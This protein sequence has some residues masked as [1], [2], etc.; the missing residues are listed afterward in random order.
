MNFARKVGFAALMLALSLC[1]GGRH[2][3]AQTQ[4][5]GAIAGTITDPS[6]AAIPGAKITIT[7]TG[8][9]VT[10]TVKSGAA[11]DFSVGL[12]QPGQYTVQ[13]AAPGFRTTQQSVAVAVGQAA[14]V[15]IALAIAQGVQTVQVEGTAV[16]ILQ[17]ENSNLSTTLTQQQVQNLP[18]PG[19]D[20]TDY[21]NM[22]AGV[23]E[24]TNGMYG[25]SSAFGLPATSNNFTIN[26]AE[27]DDPFLNLNNSGPSNLLLG[28]N[29]ISEA[30]IVANAYSAQYGAL[31]G[32]Q[33]NIITRSGTNQFHGNATWYWTNSDLNANDWFNDSAGAPEPFANANQW[34]AAVGGPIK[35]D[36]A[37]FFVNYE[38]LRFVTSPVST[39]FL[40]GMDYEQNSASDAGTTGT[41]TNKDGSTYSVVN[42]LSI[43][44]EDGA[45]DNNT[46]TLY[47]NG[48]GSECA[49]YQ[50]MFALYNGTPHR[51]LGVAQGPLTAG[52]VV[53]QTTAAN[54]DCT[55][56]Y[57]FPNG[58]DYEDA[59]PGGTKN[60][61]TEVLTTARLDL[62]L[63]PNDTAFIHFNRDNGLQP[64][65]VDPIDPAAFNTDSQQPDYQGQMEETHTFSPTLVN[66]FVLSGMWYSALFV[67]ANPSLSLSTMPY[68]LAF[69]DGSF[70]G[71]GAD[72][73]AFP[74]G[75]NVTQAQINDDVSWIRGKHTIS[76]GFLGKR[77]DV[78]DA[79]LG[80][81]TEMEGESYGP[82]ASGP[83]GPGDSF[84][85]GG[86]F[87]GVMRFPQRLE[88][89]I[90]TLNL[91]F[92][93]QDEWKPTSNLEL[94]GGIRLEHNE[95]PACGTSC[96][97]RLAGNY[98]QVSDSL[99]TPYNQIIAS[100]L[101]STFNGY[102]ALA[103]LPRVG[104][105]YSLPNHRTTLFRGGFGMFTDVFPATIADDLLDNAPLNATFVYG[106]GLVDPSQPGSTLNGVKAV[107]AAF[108][109]GF[110]SGGSYTSIDT[111]DPQFANAP[112]SV[113]N[114][115]KNLHYPTYEEWSV[116]LQQ[117]IGHRDGISIG[118]VGNHGYHE[119]VQNNGVNLSEAGLPAPGT[120]TGASLG[121]CGQYFCGL[122]A[123]TPLP[124]FDGVT[125]VQS[126]AVS[127][128]NG[129]LISVQH[130][131][132][133]AIAAVNY[134]WSHA[135][136][137]ISN[138]GILPFAGDSL[139]IIDP[140]NLSQNYG[141][142]DYDI[143]HNLNANYVV[144]VPYFGGPKFLTDRWQLG[145]T[146]FFR[147]GFPFSVTDSNVTGNVLYEGGNYAGSMLADIANPSVLHTHCG[148]S[149]VSGVVGGTPCLSA[150]DFSDP[151]G[152]GDA[153]AQRR[154][155]FNGPGW[156]DTDFNVMK[157]FRIPGTEAG[158]IQIGAV[159][160][161]VLNH[162]NFLNPS[163]NVSNGSTFGTIYAPA[164]SVPTSVFGAF[165]GGDASPRILQLKANIQF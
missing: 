6:G 61:L 101:K 87:Y 93:A 29:D 114:V 120:V 1:I 140:F 118:Y 27:D 35:H 137:E 113:F 158:Q 151:T 84:S 147:T 132:K 45:C 11:G 62:K 40:P 148:K 156:F 105:T 52:A 47:L 145:G 124:E 60:D 97:A 88:E 129:L 37:W 58:L 122:P 10:K 138:G 160:Y 133:V 99:T 89:P 153:N 108:Q 135:M 142:A 126:A 117:Q 157:G 107:N 96:F 92:Y 136:D 30:S 65:G 112:P 68:G 161:N 26:G 12:L 41:A 46:S 51:S 57:A 7:D 75:R 128:Y 32:V 43:L 79:D 21:I 22:T 144:T 123:N 159:A 146:A 98:N 56:G 81:L 9:G 25:N 31:G 34:G 77:D 54:G 19:G 71:L 28:S 39:V 131:G 48:E 163:G 116:Q 103:V 23:V 78:T 18:N 44:G 15:N 36:R 73:I 59:L 141:N 64:T 106:G 155:Q 82:A 83:L 154:N 134:T 3:A 50:H 110:S 66:Q 53:C 91:G 24:N 55:S 143:R 150:S 2:A 67:D 49:F 63:G 85:Q 4:I 149:A 125:E 86:L 8:T 14:T 95:N 152:F 72:D 13:V 104:F 33:E 16:P 121:P 165:L 130:Q 74:Q 94:T 139:G 69:Y 90:S 119:P 111:T 162:I 100:G 109:S 80:V 102:Q 38:G 76:F 127:N 115:D 20:I 5:S 42:D 70:N 17:T 164:A